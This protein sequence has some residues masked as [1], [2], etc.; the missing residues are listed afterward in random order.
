MA[1]GL[2]FYSKNGD[3]KAPAHG[4][5]FYT[6]S[7]ELASSVFGIANASIFYL[8]Y[9]SST[10]C[11]HLSADALETFPICEAIKNHKIFSEKSLEIYQRLSNTADIKG[12][13]TRKGDEIEYV[14]FDMGSE[15]DSIDVLDRILAEY[16]NFTP[17]E[18][19]FI[20]NYDIKYR[21]GLSGAP[22]LD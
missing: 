2:P 6:E 7:E 20:I 5:H 15:K 9:I 8:H 16:Y 4:R 18:L 13:T 17:E 22:S 1:I 10:D 11:F 14:E 3:I 19:D 21:M 12:M